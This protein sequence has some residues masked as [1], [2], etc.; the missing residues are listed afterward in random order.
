MGIQRRDG[1]WLWTGGPVPPG[2]AGI[3]LGRLVIVRTRRLT[4]RLLRHELVHVDQF[5]RQG[6]V[7]FV[8]TYLGHYLRWRLRGYPHHAAYRRIPHEVEAYW[9]ERA[10]EEPTPEHRYAEATSPS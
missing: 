2:S 10:P 9:R 6:I 5:A 8:V 1:Y 4:P 3:T 7:R